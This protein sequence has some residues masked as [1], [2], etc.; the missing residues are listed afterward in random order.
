LRSTPKGLNAV[1]L[2][3]VNH[4]LQSLLELIVADMD[5]SCREVEENVRITA[6]TEA[7]RARSFLDGDLSALHLV[8]VRDVVRPEAF[9]HVVRHHDDVLRCKCHLVRAFLAILDHEHRFAGVYDEE[10]HVGNSAVPCPHGKVHAIG[11]G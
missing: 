8:H 10:L 11:T 7:I 9:I 2:R 3:L 6:C 4:A 5:A 1:L